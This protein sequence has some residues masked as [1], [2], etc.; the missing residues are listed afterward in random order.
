LA[1]QILFVA[2]STFG[3]ISDPFGVD[4]GGVDQPKHRAANPTVAF[5]S[6]PRRPG[7]IGDDDPGAIATSRGFGRGSNPTLGVFFGLFGSIL[8]RGQ[9]IRPIQFATHESIEQGGF[10]SIGRTQNGHHQ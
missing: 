3:Q 4:T 9:S 10:A 5:A 2:A 6:I 7:D 1:I 8:F